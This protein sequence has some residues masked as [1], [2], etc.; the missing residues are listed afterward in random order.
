MDLLTAIRLR[1]PHDIQMVIYHYAHENHYACQLQKMI[2]H[3]RDSN[4]MVKN[5]TEWI[6]DFVRF[7]LDNEE[8]MMIRYMLSRHHPR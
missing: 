5:E 4:V 3:S 1:L 8:Y 6:E 7:A 2:S